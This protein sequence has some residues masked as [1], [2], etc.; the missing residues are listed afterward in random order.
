MIKCPIKFFAAAALILGGCKPARVENRDRESAA[1]VETSTISLPEKVSFN[2]HIQPILSEKCY[3]CHGPDSGTR[4]PK[5]APLRLDREENAFAPRENGKP[6][7]LKG[8]PKDSL[9]V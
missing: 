5:D 7:I 8:N 4:A 9:L 2:E 6:V 3:H 1:K